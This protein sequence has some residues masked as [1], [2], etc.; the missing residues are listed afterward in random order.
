LPFLVIG[1]S[2]G[3]DVP[4]NDHGEITAARLKSLK[5]RCP[6][7]VELAMTTD[8]E[9]GP[10]KKEPERRPT[11]DED[12]IL[13]DLANALTALGN[14]LA[15]ATGIRQNAGQSGTENL[16]QVLQKCRAQHE[17]AV[18]SLRELQKALQK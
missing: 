10:P 5:T 17:R 14:H 12:K 18:W 3:I 2:Y 4:Q 6:P 11:T 9:P 15:L 7:G 8:R 16:D 13:L 1:S